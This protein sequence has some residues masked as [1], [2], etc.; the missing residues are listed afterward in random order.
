MSAH[1]NPNHSL[2]M[3]RVMT[4]NSPLCKRG[5]KGD[6]NGARIQKSPSI[7]LLPRGKR[8]EFS[9][10]LFGLKKNQPAHS[11]TLCL[12]LCLCVSVVGGLK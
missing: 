3:N 12:S 7:P 2:D 6:L 4:I 1:L 9:N 5:A 10:G 8:V 11:E